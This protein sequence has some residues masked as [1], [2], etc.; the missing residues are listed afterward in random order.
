MLLEDTVVLLE[1]VTAGL[2]LQLLARHARKLGLDVFCQQEGHCDKCNTGV[3]LLRSTKQTRALF[4]ELLAHSRAT[5]EY[6]GTEAETDGETWTETVYRWDQDY[7]NALI[8]V[9]GLKRA[10]IPHRYMQMGGLWDDP[11]E[12]L[13]SDTILHRSTDAGLD[14]D[15][16]G[17]QAARILEEAA[18]LKRSF[19]FMKGWHSLEFRA[20]VLLSRLRYA[21]NMQPAQDTC[22]T[23]KLKSDVEV[24]VEEGAPGTVIKGYEEWLAARQAQAAAG[25]AG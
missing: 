14:G 15:D 23:D 6:D 16:K 12:F 1:P 21:L 17:K 5:D 19:L 4:V 2:G 3:V 11:T 25:V 22:R 7:A 13:T 9:M 10:Y 24:A 20:A 8:T 18:G